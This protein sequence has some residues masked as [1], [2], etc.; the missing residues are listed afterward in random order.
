M[1]VTIEQINPNERW[2]T[3]PDKGPTDADGCSQPG[4][5]AQYPSLVVGVQFGGLVACIRGGS[6]AVWIGTK[7]IIHADVAGELLLGA[8]DDLNGY[9]DNWGAITF[10]VTWP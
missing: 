7:G 2:C 9:G 6:R 1:V 3:H 5:V 4:E 10:R 8:N